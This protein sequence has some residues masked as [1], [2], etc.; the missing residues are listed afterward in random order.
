MRLL[1]VCTLLGLI[2]CQ[3]QDRSNVIPTYPDLP[4]WFANEAK[5][6]Q[7]AHAGLTKTVVMNSDSE[8]IAMTAP[9]WLHEFAVLMELD[10]NKPAYLGNYV[11]DTTFISRNRGTILEVALVAKKKKMPI[12]SIKFRFLRNT[13]EIFSIEAT[14]K[15][16]SCLYKVERMLTY[17]SG[18]GYSI[19]SRQQTLLLDPILL[20]IRAKVDW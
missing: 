3:S 20:H 12:T 16:R 9:D 5:T 10:L 6:L 2:G 4:G 7:E 13:A 1:L 11:A 18:V 8:H 19:R 17:G 14:Y 15:K